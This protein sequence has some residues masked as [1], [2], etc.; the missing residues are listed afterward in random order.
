M[1]IFKCNF[2]KFSRGHAPGLP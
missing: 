2:A 1:R